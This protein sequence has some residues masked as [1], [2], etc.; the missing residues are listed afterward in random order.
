MRKAVVAFDVRAAR[1]CDGRCKA[2]HRLNQAG[3]KQRHQHQ[4]HAVQSSIDSAVAAAN[5]RVVMAENLARPRITV[6]VGVPGYRDARA[7]GT[8]KRIIRVLQTIAGVAHQGK[9]NDRVV[10]LAQQ[11]RTLASPQVVFDANRLVRRIHEFDLLAILLHRRHLQ[12]PSQAV[13]EGESRL[14]VPG[15][16]EIDVV[17][18]ESCSCRMPG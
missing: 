8:I 5:D 10:Y 14:H 16:A 12:R 9:T 6:E 3:A 2:L 11:C 15:V 4:V 7:E 13:G 1:T 18:R 17:E